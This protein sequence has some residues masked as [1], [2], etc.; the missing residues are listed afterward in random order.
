MNAGWEKRS[1]DI[2]DEAKASL[3]TDLVTAFA[4]IKDTKIEAVIGDTEKGGQAARG[5]V[6]AQRPLDARTS[7]SISKPLSRVNAI[8][9]EVLPEEV[10]L[11]ATTQ[12]GDR[13]CDE[14]SRK[15]LPSW[16]QAPTGAARSCCAIP[17]MPR[18]TAPRSKCQRRWASQSGSTVSMV[19][20]RRQLLAGLLAGLCSGQ[21]VRGRRRCNQRLFISCRMDAAG[22]ASVACFDAEGTEVFATSLPARGHDVTS[23]P[24][25]EEAVVFARRPG[26]WFVVVASRPMAA[27]NPSFT[28]LRGGTSMDTACSR[29]MAGCCM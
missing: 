1:G 18:R 4:I 15:I 11:P 6:L 28:R 21:A 10:A 27:S 3:A 16:P 23:R 7:F 29:P 8:L 19:I 12:I 20:D 2:S 13:H 22:T 25:A 17:S 9:F 5:G 14:A 24:G 26:N